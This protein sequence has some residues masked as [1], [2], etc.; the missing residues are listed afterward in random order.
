MLEK[1]TT[2]YLPYILLFLGLYFFIKS[3]AHSA[4]PMPVSHEFYFQDY[5]AR[6]KIGDK[7]FGN[8][9]REQKAK[10]QEEYE[11]HMFHAIRTYNDA[12]EKCWWLPSPGDRDIARMC[13]TT[14]ISTV[15][16]PTPQLKIVVVVSQLLIHYGLDCIDEWYFIQDKLYWSEYHFNQCELL[17]KNIQ[18]T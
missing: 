2:Y 1:F 6:R 16:A 15:V 5:Q 10:W 4:E 12:K 8:V 17:Q 14:A 18:N 3:F 11:F 7:P 13:W 9:S